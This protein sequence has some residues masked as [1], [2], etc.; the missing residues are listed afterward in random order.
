MK[1]VLLAVDDTKGAIRATETL[2][3]FFSAV[4]PVHVVLVYVEKMLGR[5]LLGEAL[6]SGPEMDEMRI[7]LKDTDYQQMLDKKAAKIITYYTK[8]LNDAGIATT[9]PVVK[10]GH[11]AE[12]IINI[13]KEEAA[14]LIVLGSRGDRG[15]DF[16]I[17]SVSREVANTSP[18]P[19]LLAR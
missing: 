6:G 17:G 19:V 16:L 18:I 11:P 7:A 8:M 1:K 12:E 4:K 14:E 13:A 2:I 15:H 5:S 10:E 3:K 9:K